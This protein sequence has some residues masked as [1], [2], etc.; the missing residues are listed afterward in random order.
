MHEAIQFYIMIS[1]WSESRD[2]RECFTI[3]DLFGHLDIF[4]GP[5]AQQ[6]RLESNELPPR[7]VDSPGWILHADEEQLQC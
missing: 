2:W 1:V 7:T 3:V 6:L 4:P 5:D